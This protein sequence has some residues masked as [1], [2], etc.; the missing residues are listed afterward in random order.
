MAT[1]R[2]QMDESN[3]VFK[4]IMQ[5]NLKLISDDMIAQL[6]KEYK[7]L[8][9]SD[10]PNAVNSVKMR[11]QGNYSLELKTAT[12]LSSSDAI[13]LAID[14][15]DMKPSDFKFS[16]EIKLGEFD[17]LPKGLR[18]K[19]N[20]R[21]VLT[22]GAQLSDIE[23]NLFFE[24]LD[25]IDRTDSIIEIEEA[26]EE[27]ATKYIQ[28]NS[29]SVGSQLLSSYTV[30]DSRNEV[31]FSDEGKAGMDALRFEN[32]SPVADI[33]IS[34]NG[35]IFSADQGSAAQYFPPLHF[36]CKSVLIPIP[37]GRL[38]NREIVKLEPQGTPTE[39]AAA[40]KSKQFSDNEVIIKCPCCG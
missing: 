26:L 13:E 8:S 1:P 33:C 9:R 11:G 7:K 18:V 31:F 10:Q 25:E 5:S 28:G 40:K 12:A 30:N 35:Q 17:D 14:Q 29:V 23:K 39:V 19:L 24:Y 32:P 20:K 36:N 38:G 16:D 22:I 37:K 6:I 2:K 21:V 15:L 3:K 34:L 27:T 4:E